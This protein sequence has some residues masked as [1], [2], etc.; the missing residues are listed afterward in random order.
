[1]VEGERLEER[2]LPWE[3]VVERPVRAIEVGTISGVYGVRGWVR[4]YSYTEPRENILS[5]DP[6]LVEQGGRWYRVPLRGGRSQGKGVVAHL[7][8]CEDRDQA[9]R[10]VGARVAIERSQLPPLEDDEY[11]WS[12]LVGLE[13]V[14]REGVV[15]GKVET[16]LETGAHDVM[17]VK[18][19]R[20]HLIPF[21]PGPFVLKVDL[22]AG[23]IRVDWGVDF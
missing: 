19:A 22:A 18:G 17:V 23:R 2:S 16:L 11:Y 20:E 7:F 6:W 9:V 8:G 4:V 12:D 5:Y 3:P 21:V 13:V 1:V 10:L 14:N 15:L